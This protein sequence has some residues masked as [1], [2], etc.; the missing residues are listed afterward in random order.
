MRKNLIVY[1]AILIAV[2]FWGMSF[3]WTKEALGNFGPFTIVFS[4][5]AISALIL[6]TI[7]LSLRKLQLPTKKNI[8]W[9]ILL[10]FFEPFL[11]FLGETNGMMYVTPTLAAVVIATIPLFSPFVAYFV[12]KEKFGISNFAGLL[13]SFVGVGMVILKDDFTFSASTQGLLLLALA[14]LSVLGFSSVILKIPREINTFTI[15]TYQS[16]LGALYFLPLFFI[17]EFDHFQ[18]VEKSWQAFRPILYLAVFASTISFML[19]VYSIRRIGMIRTNAF[20]NLIPVF[21]A[22]FSYFIF[23][24]RLNIVN[25]AGIGLVVSGLFVAQLVKKSQERISKG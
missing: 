20:S 22:I 21:T 15:I 17:F 23:D 7:G 1:F 2:L 13:V 19:F 14:V 8:Y 18:S 12:S 16:F 9:I 3:I 10:A 24:E 25:I 4:R 6:V 11:Y 5:F